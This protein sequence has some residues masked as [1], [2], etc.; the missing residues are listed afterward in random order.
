MVLNPASDQLTSLTAALFNHGVSVTQ[1]DGTIRLSAHVSTGD[2]TLDML[3]GA[4]VSF[5]RV[6]AG[7]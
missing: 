3:R 2:E 7:A 1:R 6:D 4:L 5:A